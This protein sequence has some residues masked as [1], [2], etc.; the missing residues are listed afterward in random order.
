MAGS[1]SE[2]RSR[3]LAIAAYKM[4][5]EGY[6]NRQIAAATGKKVEAVPDM[7][8]RGERLA[9]DHESVCRHGSEA[10]LNR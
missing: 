7:V 5:R 6:T 1:G 9:T 8:K 10:T 4:R 3:A 2:K